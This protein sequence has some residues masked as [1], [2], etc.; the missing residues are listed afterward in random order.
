MSLINNKTIA[1]GVVSFDS[2]TKIA[3]RADGFKP[4]GT[5]DQL[6]EGFKVFDTQNNGT[7]PASE[8]RHGTPFL[9]LLLLVFLLTI[10]L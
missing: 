9:F 6:I 4:A 7:I 3:L 2:F 5:T 1:T 10:T 8:L